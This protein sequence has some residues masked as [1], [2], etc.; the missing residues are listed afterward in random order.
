M[1]ISKKM[2]KFLDFGKQFEQFNKCHEMH[3]ICTIDK[4]RGSHLFIE[5]RSKK[6]VMLCFSDRLDTWK[7]GFR[8]RVATLKN[9]QI[10]LPKDIGQKMKKSLDQPI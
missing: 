10:Q 5:R 1:T 9:P 8:Y 7:L 6:K 2:L 3:L 4:K